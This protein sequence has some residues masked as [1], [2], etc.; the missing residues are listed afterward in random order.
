MWKPVRNVILALLVTACITTSVAE[1]EWLEQPTRRTTNSICFVVDTSGS[2]GGDTFERALLAVNQIMGVPTDDLAVSL[3]I[4]SGDYY[5]WEGLPPE[6]GEPAEFWVPL[7]D[8]RMPEAATR[9]IEGIGS[10]GSTNPYPALHHALALNREDLTII[11]V[12][13]GDFGVRSTFIDGL[14]AAQNDRTDRGLGP[15]VIGCY[16]VDRRHTYSM[17]RIAELGQGG[18]YMDAPPLDP[19]ELGNGPPRRVW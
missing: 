8:A 7:P 10:G 17:R 1:A 16:G 12:S 9:W 11:L 5:P 2:M 18:F 13:D 19:K 3:I 4:F 6:E 15:A 14:E